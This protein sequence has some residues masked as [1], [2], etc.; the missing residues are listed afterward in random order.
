MGQMFVFVSAGFLWTI[1]W[2]I[3]VLAFC[4]LSDVGHFAEETERGTINQGTLAVRA[5]G[6]G[7]QHQKSM[8]EWVG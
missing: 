6:Q 5:G 3:F 1:R 8:G 4:F 7:I 2:P